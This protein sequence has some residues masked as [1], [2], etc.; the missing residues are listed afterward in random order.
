M[1]LQVLGEQKQC[2]WKM[3]KRKR[4][5]SQPKPK[6]PTLGKYFF[7]DGRLHKILKKNIPANLMEAWSYEDE[8][9][10][11]ILYTDYRK[12]AKMAVR[13]RAAAEIINVSKRTL[14]RAYMGGFINTP[15]R[16]YSIKGG[17]RNWG[18]RWWA[19]ENIIEAHDYFLSVHR[20]RPRLDGDNLPNQK[21]P[22][23]AEII[24]KMNNQLVLYAK[25]G[26]RYIA[27]YTPPQ[28]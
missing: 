9:V 8:C 4:Y 26:E 22:T 6:R 2:V 13:T 1:W 28:F 11:T 3:A 25:D 18:P 23:R 17:N 19:I 20:G 12:S 16:S 5:V 24:A 27:T 14:I 21:I 10:V 7:L 15:P